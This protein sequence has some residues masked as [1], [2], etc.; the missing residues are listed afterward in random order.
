M[1]T[2]HNVYR[3]GKRLISHVALKYTLLEVNFFRDGF[4][5]SQLGLWMKHVIHSR[6]RLIISCDVTI[7]TELMGTMRWGQEN[8]SL[9]LFFRACKILG[10]SYNIISAFFS[11]NYIYQ[12]CPVKRWFHCLLN[13]V[14]LRSST[15]TTTN[16]S[17]VPFCRSQ[18][19]FSSLVYFSSSS[20]PG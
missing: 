12:N 20:L 14:T 10:R 13:K 2:T 19:T 8:D 17:L 16:Q 4:S 1:P 11:W 15:L 9:L 5:F 3:C 7:I 18:K 6:K